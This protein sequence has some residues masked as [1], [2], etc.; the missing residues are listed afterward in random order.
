MITYKDL[1]F[2]QLAY[3]ISEKSE[4][5]TKVGSV[6]VNPLNDE[7][8]SYGFNDFPKNVDKNINERWNNPLKGRYIVHS[9]VSA[10]INSKKDVSG[11]DIYVNLYPC[12]NCAG[13][14]VNAGIKRVFCESKPDFNNEKWG[15]SWNISKIIFEEANIEVIFINE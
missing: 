7:V 4:D 11:C 2:M 13:A 14:I 1:E 6:I 5:S 15:I 9:E 3:S 12:S 8:I 10:I